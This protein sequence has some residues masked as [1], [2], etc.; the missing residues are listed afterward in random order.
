MNQFDLP[1]SGCSHLARTIVGSPACGD[2]SQIVL[3][4]SDRSIGP[5]LARNWTDAMR[6]N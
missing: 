5:P 3:I 1:H 4:R 6:S 2:Q